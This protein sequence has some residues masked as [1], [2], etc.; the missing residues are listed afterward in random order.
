MA[1]P[2]LWKLFETTGSISAYLLLKRIEEA[3]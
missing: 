1:D 2:D 3:G